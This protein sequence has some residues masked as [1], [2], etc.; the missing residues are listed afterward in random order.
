MSQ[1]EI[2]AV[3][4]AKRGR[5][6]EAMIAEVGAM[7][8]A[9]LSWSVIADR[10]GLKQATLARRFERWRAGGHTEMRVP[11]PPQPGPSVRKARRRE[12]ILAE[13]EMGRL[14]G[15]RPE[16]IAADLGVKQDSLALSFDRWRERGYTDIEFPRERSAA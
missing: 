12:A 8:E 15:L 9:G 1:A 7:V 5:E 11:Y 3:A 2:T 14:I 4:A 16:Q 13:V 10:L 6:R